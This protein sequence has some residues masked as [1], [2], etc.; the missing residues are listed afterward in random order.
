MILG[1]P[2]VETSSSKEHTALV[3]IAQPRGRAALL[4]RGASNASALKKSDVDRD[5]Q[6]R[7]PCSLIFGRTRQSM[8]RSWTAAVD[9]RNGI[10]MLLVLLLLC[11]DG[12]QACTAAWPASTVPAG[13]TGAGRLVLSSHALLHRCTRAA[14]HVKQCSMSCC[15]VESTWS[16]VASTHCAM[17]AM[18]TRPFEVSVSCM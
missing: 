9:W 8:H 16:S 7:E 4:H 3:G 5:H 14:P 15:L 10:E 6:C 11:D 17:R 1:V 12:L 18:R 13:G 2:R